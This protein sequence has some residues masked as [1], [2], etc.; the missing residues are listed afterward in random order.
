MAETPSSIEGAVGF[1]EQVEVDEN[2]PETV[3]IE[4]ALG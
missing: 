4:S 2:E 3:S 1:V